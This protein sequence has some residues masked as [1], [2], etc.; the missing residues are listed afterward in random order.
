MAENEPAAQRMLDVGRPLRGTEYRIV[1]DERRNLPERRVGE[2]AIRSRAVMHGYHMNPE[3]ASRSLDAEGWYFTGD[4]GYRV[5]NTFFV[6]GRKSD[7]IIVSGVNIYP[8]DIEAIVAEHPHA[9]A[10]RIA[11]IGEEDTKLGTQKIV[12]IIESK[13]SDPKVH[14]DTAQYA[15]TEVTRRLNVT[16]GRIVH[17]PYKWLIK[18]SNGKIAQ[19][20]NLKRL[21]E[22]EGNAA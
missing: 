14:Q 2:V 10:G 21:P 9:V 15:R 20:P 13:S 19:V 5:G 3:A 7:L 6:T 4:M 18:T 16:V 22:L 11:A 12:L 8:Q 1:D 17:A